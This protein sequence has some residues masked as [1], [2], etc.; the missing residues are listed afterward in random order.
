MKRLLLPLLAALALPTAVNAEPVWIEVYR[1][2][3]F[4]RNGK[5]IDD[6]CGFIWYI[7][8][9]SIVKNKK[10]RYFN[11]S[12]GALVTNGGLRKGTDLNKDI[13]SD[14]ADCSKEKLF[15]TL[16]KKVTL[17]NAAFHDFVCNW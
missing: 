5:C 12:S 3:V 2:N 13:S 8:V 17:V 11:F 9:K 14:F 4:E 7:D 15:S 16:E 10:K 1:T 6:L